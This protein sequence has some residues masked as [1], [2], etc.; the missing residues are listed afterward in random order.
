MFNPI[1]GTIFSQ[2]QNEPKRAILV[3]YLNTNKPGA[4][5]GPQHLDNCHIRLLRHHAALSIGPSFEGAHSSAITNKSL[6]MKL[7]IDMSN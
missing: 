3:S 2:G 4:L 6:Q 7:R 5:L 1:M